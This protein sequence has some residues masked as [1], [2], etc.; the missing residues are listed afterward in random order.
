MT[1]YNENKNIKILV[2]VSGISRWFWYFEPHFKVKD[3]E[4]ML[5]KQIFSFLDTIVKKIE[6]GI[7]NNK[8]P[9]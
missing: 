4:D 7:A 3:D 1:H 6:N 8:K 2:S 9:T 5:V